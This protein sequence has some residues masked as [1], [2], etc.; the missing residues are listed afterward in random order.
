MGIFTS[1][2]WRNVGTLGI[3]SKEDS[4]LL[5][6]QY[7]AGAPGGGNSSDADPDN[8]GSANAEDDDIGLEMEDGGGDETDM[9]MDEDGSSEG[10]EGGM[11]SDDMSSDDSSMDTDNN[12]SNPNKNPFK[13]Q[14][15][16]SMLDDKLAE[17][18]TTVTDTLDRIYAN[19]K[20]EQVVVSELENLSD[21]IRNI[22]ET[23]YVVPVDAT[24]YKY[25]LSISAY[26][27][28][29]EEICKSLNEE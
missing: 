19:P 23:V 8:K 13:N 6:D 27:L 16:K 29:A 10:E 4:P 18:Q 9:L 7:D 3:Y 22:R 11:E 26:K 1:E 21:S 15:G 25:R 28:L 24:L 2:F 20:I 12:S 17:L 5:A 14:N